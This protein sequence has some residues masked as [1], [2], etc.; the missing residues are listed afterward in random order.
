MVH[1]YPQLPEGPSHLSRSQLSRLNPQ[2]VYKRLVIT[3]RSL[4]THLRVLPAH[5]MARACK[6]SGVWEGCADGRCAMR[7]VVAWRG[8]AADA[9]RARFASTTSALCAG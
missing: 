2:S 9:A 6:V 8:A 7:S 3:L 5:R 1:Y 4:Y